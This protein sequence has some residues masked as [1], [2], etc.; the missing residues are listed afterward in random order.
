[1]LEFSLV[2]PIFLVLTLGTAVLALGVSQFQ[3]VAVLAREG[4]RWASIRGAEYQ[5]TT[6]K[7]AASAGDVYAQAILPRAPGIAPGDISCGV[8]WSPDNRPGST[9]SVT[10]NY[11]WTPAA[12]LGTINISDTSVMTVA[13]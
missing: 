12:Y 13:Y 4:A 8:A 7:A 5:Q 1:M 2:L 6:G 3:L 9:V 10:I 11:R